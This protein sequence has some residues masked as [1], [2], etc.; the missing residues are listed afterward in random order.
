MGD[1]EK[2][3]EEI[4]DLVQEGPFKK[5]C[6]AVVNQ[7]EACDARG[8]HRVDVEREVG[9]PMICYD[10]DLFFDKDDAESMDITYRI[11][12]MHSKN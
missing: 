6:R 11:E 7:R 5:S 2:K 9:T 10:C 4:S 12:P 3:P 8:Y 1:E